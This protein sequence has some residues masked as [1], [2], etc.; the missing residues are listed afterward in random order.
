MAGVRCRALVERDRNHPSVVFWGIYNENPGATALS[1]DELLRFTRG[2]DPTRVVVEDSGGSLAIDQDFGWVDRAR[3]I[4]DRGFAPEPSQDVHVYVGAPVTT[5]VYEWL[6]TLGSVP[7]ERRHRGRRLRS[8]ARAGRV[9]PPPARLSRARSS[10]RSWAMAAWPIWTRW[11]PAMAIAATWSMPRRC[12]LSAT[13]C[14]PGLPP[15]RLERV[16]GS[17]AG[18]IAAS[19]ALQAA[20]VTR[21]IEAVLLNRR[22]SGFVVTQLNDV[23]WEF[24]A[25]LL[26]HWRQ[27]KP[28]Y[29][30]VQR[31]NRPHCLVLHA[32]RPADRRR[33]AGGSECEPGG[34]QPACRGRVD[35]DSCSGS[36]RHGRRVRQLWASR[37]AKA[38]SKWDRS[39][40]L[41]TGCRA[42]SPSRPR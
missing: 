24:H 42:S 13:V 31:L 29:Y 14:T 41:W 39:T 35:P 16:F 2:L 7:P 23:A 6:R 15:A 38:S 25:G 30:A 11:W 12:R 10:C 19:Q 27:P 34:P 8:F 3:M 9:L 5:G 17:V 36:G 21:Q 32:A 33:R 4:P 22:V 20:A 1:G 37:R 40:C 28:V 26:D 18:L